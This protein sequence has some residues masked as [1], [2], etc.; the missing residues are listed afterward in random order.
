MTDK[1]TKAPFVNKNFL[2]NGGDVQV[3]GAK[4][5]D[6][7]IE[8]IKN[9]SIEQI[10]SILISFSKLLLSIPK[11]ILQRLQTKLFPGS[12][13][14]KPLNDTFINPR[15]QELTEYYTGIFGAL[16]LFW[17]DEFVASARNELLD[18]IKNE[19]FIPIKDMALDV[20]NDS[21]DELDKL[22]NK[23]E[24]KAKK[25]VINSVNAGWQSLSAAFPP[26]GMI[27][28]GVSALSAGAVSLAAI[29]NVTDAIFSVINESTDKNLDKTKKYVNFIKQQSEK[30]KALTDWYLQFEQQIIPNAVSDLKSQ[31]I[32]S[33]DNTTPTE[34]KETPVVYASPSVPPLPSST[35]V[36]A[37][38]TE[39]KETP[40]V[41]ATP[42]TKGGNRK[43]KKTKK[44]HQKK[45]TKTRKKK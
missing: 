13:D 41:N 35:Q 22:G 8:Q 30:V 9:M 17:D 25:I 42:V 37:T 31:K 44:K 29:A 20:L 39:V 28:A 3:L 34:V 12:P 15:L 14:D 36:N 16:S 21:T 32:P 19:F 24:D 33:V 1:I 6:E 5:S 2:A 27:N 10:N 18:K 23:F 43:F 7:L 40:V 45:R 4:K 11:A 38:P 26:L